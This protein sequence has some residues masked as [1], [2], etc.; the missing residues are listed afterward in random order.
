MIMKDLFLKIL[1]YGGLVIAFLLPFPFAVGVGYN[2]YYVQ[3]WPLAVAV[4]VAGCILVGLFFAVGK[5]VGK[6]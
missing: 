5:M 3:E 2:L 4:T 1:Y 6:W